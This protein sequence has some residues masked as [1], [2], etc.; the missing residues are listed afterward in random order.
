MDIL[1]MV[2]MAGAQAE[3]TAREKREKRTLIC[4][5]CRI[6]YAENARCCVKCGSQTTMTVAQLHEHDARVAAEQKRQADADLAV[7]ARPFLVRQRYDAIF[8]HSFCRTCF[9]LR[10]PSTNFCPTCTQQ[11]TAQPPDGVVYDL[12]HKEFPDVVRTPDDVQRIASLS[13]PPLPS[14]GS[15]ALTVAGWGLE[16]A[17]KG[18]LRLFR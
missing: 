7:R 12:L 14:V 15:A 18:I 16:V 5:T 8:Q 9:A 2:L 11:C 3:K 6:E 13:V 17:S 10:P 4:P 1:R